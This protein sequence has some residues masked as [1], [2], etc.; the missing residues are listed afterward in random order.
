MPCYHPLQAFYSLRSDG[1]KHIMF[2]NTLADMYQKG[3]KP[4]G[5]ALSIPCGKCM[6]CRLERS[7]QWAVRCMHEASLYEDN[8]FVTLTFDDEHLL[9]C[10]NDGSLDR[11]HVQNFMKRL[12]KKFSDRKI[13][14]FYCGEYG[15]KLGRPHYHLLLFNLDFPDRKYYK[16]V[17][18]FKYFNSE[19]L[20]SIWT[21][22]H[23]VIGD[24]SFE[25]AAYVARYCTKKVTGKAADDYYKGK[26][27]EFAQAS[28]KP[29]LANE[30]FQ[31][32]GMSDIFPLDECVVR[33]VKC[34]PP[35]YYDKLLEAV[36]PALLEQVKERRVKRAEKQVK[37]NTYDRLLVR[38]KCQEARM[39]QLVRTM[40]RS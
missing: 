5:D 14:S 30:W 10:C 20:S 2:S 29:G 37:D 28:L 34:K 27:P 4:S 16:S 26:L 21:F 9:K 32:F 25:S 13:R 24:V 15:D 38:E 31:Q 23:A 3:I 12:R 6:G 8:C 7:R 11:K 40:E 19:I 36:D 35:R 1:K 22:G 39:K 17:A 33:G 18:G